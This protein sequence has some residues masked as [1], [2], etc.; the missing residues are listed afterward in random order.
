MGY[1]N[2]KAVKHIVR[3]KKAL[4]FGLAQLAEKRDLETGQHLARVG[5]YVVTL[6]NELRKNRAYRRIITRQFLDDLYD[7]APLHDIGKTAVPDALLQKEAHLTPS[8]FEEMKKHVA[9]GA[10]MLQALINGFDLKDTFLVTARNIC[11]YHHEKYDGTGYLLGLSQR[12]IPLAVRIFTLCDVYDA[13]RSK[14]Y[15]KEPWSHDD[16]VKEIQKEYGKYF[17]PAVVDA[18]MRCEKL[19]KEISERDLKM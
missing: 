1:L 19:F 6:A 3:S 11:R 10:D 12:E 8:E 18:F 15:Y 14:R 9:V 17:D 7:A 4:I 13:L 5:E 16:A 2:Y